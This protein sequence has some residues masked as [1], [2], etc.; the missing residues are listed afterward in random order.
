MRAWV[1]C[2]ILVGGAAC[3][4]TDG[5]AQ[6]SPVKPDETIV[7][8]PALAVPTDDGWDVR[9]H[10]W[11]FEPRSE[12]GYALDRFRAAIG[13]EDAG[14]DLGAGSVFA[15]RAAPFLVDNERGKRIAVRLGDSRFVTE[16]SAPNGHFEGRIRLTSE[17][18]KP[19]PGGPALE[20][21]RVRAELSEGDLRRF[22]GVVLL[23][24]PSGISIVSDIDDTIKVSEVRDRKALLRNTFLLPFR[25][26]PGMAELYQTWSRQ[27]GTAFHY[28][29]A[30]PWQLYAPLEDFRRAAGFPVGTFHLRPFRWKDETALELFKAPREHK[31]EQIE[32]L[33][34]AAPA[35]RFVLVGDS[36]EMD[37]EIYG[38]L[39]RR[40]RG[41]IA[42]I[43]IRDV[44]GQ[45]ASDARYQ[46]AFEE[47]PAGSWRL[48]RNASEAPI[49][50]P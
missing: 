34:A 1:L 47:L 29:S 35:R 17:Q 32:L 33:L 3:D 48:I 20:T 9:V 24:N 30:G 27:P 45:P 43:L 36:G 23:L 7:F 15:K 19:H 5:P 49:S 46:S 13:L 8:F 50:L 21:I 44:T 12:A 41:R 26:V 14:I 37:P 31:I 38:D 39:A 18:F 6:P 2:G 42:L 40:H 22:E 25:P 16:P 4:G 28:V 10:G 11:I